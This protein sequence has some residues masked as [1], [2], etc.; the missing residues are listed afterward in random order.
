MQPRRPSTRAPAASC[1]QLAA[2]AYQPLEFGDD[3]E[4]VADQAHIRHFEDRRFAVL[5]DGDDGA[6]ILDARQM[7]DRT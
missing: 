1:Q 2:T 4:Q 6:S 3:L 7:L 5:V